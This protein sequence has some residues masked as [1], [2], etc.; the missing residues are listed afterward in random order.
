MFHPVKTSAFNYCRGLFRNCVD[1]GGRCVRDFLTVLLEGWLYL[2][3]TYATVNY[4]L[5]LIS[6]NSW[7]IMFNY[8][9]LFRGKLSSFINSFEKKNYIR[10]QL[11]DHLVEYDV[12]LCQCT[13]IVDIPP[14]MT[15][16]TSLFGNFINAAHYS[17]TSIVINRAVLHAITSARQHVWFSI[18]FVVFATKYQGKF[19]IINVIVRILHYNHYWWKPLA[20]HC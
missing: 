10:D 16:L 12:R 11:H 18:A 2:L 6:R 3:Y 8:I 13:N 1:T 14:I 5:S 17:V 19:V 9:L 15:Q 20:T 7:T 4:V